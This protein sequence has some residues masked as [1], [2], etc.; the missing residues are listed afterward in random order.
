MH[1]GEIL[2]ANVLSSETNAFSSDLM[3]ENLLFRSVAEDA[4][5]MIADFGLSRV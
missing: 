5:L 3:P 4:D 1:R 2:R